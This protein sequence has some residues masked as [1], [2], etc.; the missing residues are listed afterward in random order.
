MFIYLAGAESWC[1]TLLDMGVKN[2]LYSFYYWRTALH[3]RG[4]QKAL[5]QLSRMRR[6]KKK[7]YSF[8]LDSGAFTF[9]ANSSQGKGNM[10]APKA[11]FRDYIDFLAEY[12]DLFDIVA[13][14]DVDNWA[15]DPLTEKPVTTDQ[16]NEWILEMLDMEGL[17]PKVMPVYHQHRGQ[18]WL[19][20]WMETTASPYIGRAS[21]DV[22]GSGA[23]I[24]MAHRYGKHIHGFGQT[25][26]KTDLKYLNFDSVD[27]ITWLRADKFG[28]S[29]I[30]R[31]GTM[32]ILDHLHKADRRIY[33]DWYESWGLDFKL[34]LKDDLHENRKATII[35]WREMS[36]AFERTAALRGGGRVK[37]PYLL[38]MHLKGKPIPEVHPYKEWQKNHPE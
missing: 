20:D 14:F 27:S 4:G 38:D 8:F 18:L 6:A 3:S 9:Q 34:I 19:R 13:E 33:A 26:I 16:A 2:Q 21:S 23:A 11:Y 12:H 37:R 35:S 5:A 30:Y 25:R 32:I 17:G 1:D 24:A 31:N 22:Q 15:I 36:N 29:M 28:G 7:G 10:P